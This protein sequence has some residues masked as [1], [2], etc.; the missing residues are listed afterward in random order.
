[1]KQR[2]R[3]KVR[4]LHWNSK[5]GAHENLGNVSLVVR[6]QIRRRLLLSPIFGVI[7]KPPRIHFSAFC[8][9]MR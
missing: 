2:S 9:D 1:M 6:R 8:S 3:I 4:S 7:N 5:D